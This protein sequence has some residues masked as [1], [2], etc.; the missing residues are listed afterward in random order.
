MPEKGEK[1]L[2]GEAMPGE[3]DMSGEATV[4]DRKFVVPILRSLTAS[5]LCSKTTQVARLTIEQFYA[6]AATATAG[7]KSDVVMK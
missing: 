3:G 4:F 1:E 2:P 7:A 5:L 6:Q